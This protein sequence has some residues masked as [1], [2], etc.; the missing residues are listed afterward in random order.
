MPFEDHMSFYYMILTPNL[1]KEMRL[2]SYWKLVYSILSIIFSTSWSCWNSLTSSPFSRLRKNVH[3]SHYLVR[4]RIWN[5]KYRHVSYIFHQDERYIQKKCWEWSKI[6]S[7]KHSFFFCTW[8]PL[9][10][11]GH[12]ISYQAKSNIK[13]E[14]SRWILK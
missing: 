4:S 3:L 14:A 2:E 12:P 6:I 7:W 11:R 8:N 13:S 9:N 10:T 5:V 1:T